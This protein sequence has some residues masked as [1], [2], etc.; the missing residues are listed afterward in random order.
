[1]EGAT[2]NLGNSSSVPTFDD[3]ERIEFSYY[4]N[5]ENIGLVPIESIVVGSDECF[6][7]SEMI[8]QPS[9]NSTPFDKVGTPW[10]DA[11]R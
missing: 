1:M 5:G 8:R 7:K 6:A 2:Y 3:R 11:L 4:K 9:T 10:I